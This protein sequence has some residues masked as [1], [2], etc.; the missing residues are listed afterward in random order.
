MLFFY[1]QGFTNKSSFY[2]SMAEAP[3]EEH[4]TALRELEG[5][6]RG[7]RPRNLRLSLRTA[8]DLANFKPLTLQGQ[9]FDLDDMPAI[10]PNPGYDPAPPP[11]GSGDGGY[12]DVATST[13]TSGPYYSVVGASQ[14][15]PLSKT[16]S[17]QSEPGYA[18]ICELPRGASP[19]YTTVREGETEREK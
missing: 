13:T 17:N 11:P 18:A 6:G 14:R 3:N 12:G 1:D 2:Q 7:V 4:E 16:P 10:I 9:S 5:T 19:R 8:D 15:A